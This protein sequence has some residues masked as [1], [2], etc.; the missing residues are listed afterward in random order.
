MEGG[1][2]DKVSSVMAEASE[3]KDGKV[4]TVVMADGKVVTVVTV[5][6]ADGKVR[7][8]VT[9]VVVEGPSAAADHIRKVVMIAAG[10]IVSGVCVCD[11][12]VMPIWI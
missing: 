1:A 6:M 3:A 9:V 2:E 12:P 4:V 8:V 10:P 5:V 7:T 11:L